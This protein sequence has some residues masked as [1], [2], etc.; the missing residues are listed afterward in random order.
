MEARKKLKNLISVPFEI[1]CFHKQNNQV[2]HPFTLTTKGSI[3]AWTHLRDHTNYSCQT[4]V[5]S[6][7]LAEFEVESINKLT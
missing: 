3:E 1:R 5:G 4:C 7:S 2:L 6:M